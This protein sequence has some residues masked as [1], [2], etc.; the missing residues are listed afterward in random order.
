MDVDLGET[1]HV[2]SSLEILISSRQLAEGEFN[3]RVG[4]GTVVSVVAVGIVNLY[5]QNNSLFFKKC[6]YIPSLKRN[7]IS[8]GRLFEQYYN[9]YFNNKCVIISRNCVNICSA[10]LENCLYTLRPNI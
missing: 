5:F 1:N 9:V 2:C 10:N 7:L 6:Y 4:T 8:I 3:L